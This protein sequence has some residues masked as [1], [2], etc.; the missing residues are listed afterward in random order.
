MRVKIDPTIIKAIE[1]VM[2][3]CPTR[4]DCRLVKRNNAIWYE[5]WRG[6]YRDFFIEVPTIGHL[7]VVFKRREVQEIARD[8]A[9]IL[10]C[11]LIDP[12]DIE[13]PV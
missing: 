1:H 2:N 4:Y 3:D 12:N 13:I 9:M 11:K 6:N 5:F 7:H 8:V 10:H